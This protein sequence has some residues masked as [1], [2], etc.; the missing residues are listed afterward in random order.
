M[1]HDILYFTEENSAEAVISRIENPENER[2][3]EVMKSVITHLHA[4]VKEV[5]PT[6]EEWE[7]AIEF[8]TST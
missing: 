2:L 6:Y 7:K 5:E 4:V 8:L 1:A 3:A